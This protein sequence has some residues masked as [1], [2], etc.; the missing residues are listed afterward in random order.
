L[1]LQL[2]WTF[3]NQL[4]E[5]ERLDLNLAQINTQWQTEFSSVRSN[6]LLVGL[7]I[8]SDFMNSMVWYLLIGSTDQSIHS[9]WKINS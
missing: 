2:Y 6:N 4:P 5:I 1:A 8:M 7:N 9:R 3:N